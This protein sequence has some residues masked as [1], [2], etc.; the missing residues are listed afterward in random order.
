MTEPNTFPAFPKMPRL[1]SPC[2]ITEKIDGTNGLVEVRP[3]GTVLAGSRSRYIPLEQDNFGFAAW[4]KANEAELRDGLGEGCHYGEWWGAGIQRRYG[5]AGRHFSLFNATRWQE[6][7]PSCCLV[8]PV[9]YEGP[10]SDLVVSGALWAL[11]T[12][13]SKAAPGFMKPEGVVIYHAAAKRYFKQ[14]LDGD[15]HK[16]D[17]NG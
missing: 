15:G 8:V 13:G 17:S 9:L 12:A 16:G 5:M 2:V 14:T 3:D 1:V 4:V 10:F 6:Q 11:A 7:R